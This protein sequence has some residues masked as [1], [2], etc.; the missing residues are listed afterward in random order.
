MIKLYCRNYICCIIETKTKRH[1]FLTL[2]SL[3]MFISAFSIY[4]HQKHFHKTLSFGGEA[5]P[6]KLTQSH[7]TNQEDN[8]KC[9]VCKYF[10]NLWMK[11]RNQTL[12]CGIC[13]YN[14]V[15]VWLVKGGLSQQV[16][17]EVR[18]QVCRTG[19]LHLH[20]SF[21]A[22]TTNTEPSWKP[23]WWV[24]WKSGLL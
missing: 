23:S 8:N 11:K 7:S 15:Y 20:I 5:P 2:N 9:Q 16:H 21:Q 6:N 10:T 1:Q 18:G 13:Y 12:I 14:H 17:V 19:S 22:C 24:V 3:R 4:A